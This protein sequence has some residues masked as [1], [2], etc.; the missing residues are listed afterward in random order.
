LCGGAI[1]T[2]NHV[3]TAAHCLKGTAGYELT[4]V[5]LG[6]TFQRSKE[7]QII[8]IE[9][10]LPHPKYTQ[11]PVA[12]YD[13]AILKLARSVDYS[14]SIRPICLSPPLSNKFEE[15]KLSG[16]QGKVAGWGRTEN[17]FRSEVLKY[18]SLTI[19]G[20]S[21]CDVLYKRALREGKLG[22]LDDIN[23]L[24]SQLCA[25]GRGSTDSCSG[26]SGG[27]LYAQD[28]EG[29]FRLLGVVSYGTNRCDSSLP[30]VYTR[31]SSF[32]PWIQAVTEQ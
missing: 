13:L 25:I 20:N 19:M 6:V 2:K 28:R 32:L 29:V 8:D 10:I 22:F 9:K 21:K 7:G 3:I 26:D 31:I 24:D 23:I 1:Y 17:A 4:S 14:S 18:T 12:K 15:S 30:G 11:D 16:T 27:P 5:R